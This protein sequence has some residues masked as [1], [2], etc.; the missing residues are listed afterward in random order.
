MFH[1]KIFSEIKGMTNSILINFIYEALNIL[2]GLFFKLS[3]RRMRH[4]V[5]ILL[6]KK[7]S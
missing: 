5:E 7:I 4:V 6:L 3:V 1:E 2:F